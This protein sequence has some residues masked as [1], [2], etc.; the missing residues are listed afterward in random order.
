M[1]ESSRQPNSLNLSF[2]EDLYSDY[3]R[4]PASVPADWRRYF[5]EEI[6]PASDGLPMSA[7][8]ERVDLLIRSYRV[9]GHRVANV[10]PLGMHRPALAELDPASYGFRESD[11]ARE[12]SCHSLCSDGVLPLREILSRLRATYCGAIGAQFMHIDEPEVREWLQNRMEST[13][14]RIRLE[15]EDQLRILTRLTDAVIFEEF[16]RRKFIGAKSFSLEGSETLIPLLDIAIEKAGSEHIDE[17]VLAMAHRGR[18]N[19]LCNIMGK[20]PREIF[21]E[22]ADTE[23]EK[24]IGRGDVKYHL[25]YSSDWTTTGGRRVHLSI[26]FNPSHLEYVNPVA[27]GRMRAKQDRAGDSSREKGMVLLIHGDASFAGEGVT[28]EI[29]NLSGLEGFNVGGTLHIVVNN[30]IG[31]T[32]PIGQAASTTYCTD[33]AKM[34]QIPIFHVNGEDPESAVQVVQLAMD[35]RRTFKRDAVIDLYCYRKHG[36]SEGDEPSFTQPL[37]YKAIAERKPVRE[38]YLDH[39]LKLGSISREEADDILQRRRKNLERELLEA[40]RDVSR[41]L[42]PSLRGVWAGYAGGSDADVPDAETGVEKKRLSEL[43]EAQAN[44]PANF[45][46]HP[47]LQGG[48]QR[49]LEM[50]RGGRAV[51]WAAAEA[52][53]FASLASEGA[54]IRLSGQDSERGTFSQRHAVLHDVENDERYV[55]LQNIDP[56]QAPVEVYNSPLSEAGVL[57]FEYGYSLDCPDGLV[58]WEAQY[59]DFCNAG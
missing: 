56:Y 52:L 22:F 31:F 16:I 33:V 8:Q 10:D 51:D 6:S 36:H 1:D 26:C 23:P 27:L 37:L 43:L 44:L 45:H 29:L 17:I 40:E 18:L 20:S 19:V 55:P 34:L 4:S 32:T 11:M 35:F 7:L 42:T 57:G 13:Q 9:R 28:Q 48:I 21:R 58:L 41:E 25:G 46:V 24:F 2:L 5:D 59:G 54:R 3:L 53:A 15:R 30:Q 39:L 12:F 50:A 38:G 14:N 47:K 49:R